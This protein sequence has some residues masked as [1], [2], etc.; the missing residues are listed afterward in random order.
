MSLSGC[1]VRR[2]LV[3]AAALVIV[4][5]VVGVVV[6]RGGT[7][8]ASAA[9]VRAK[10]AEGVHFRQSISGEFSVRTRNPGAPPRGCLHF[11]FPEV[12][13]PSKFVIGPDGSYSSLTLPLDATK[14]HDIAYNARAGTETSFGLFS[15]TFSDK[16]I[17][18]F[19][20]DPASLTYGP[21]AQ[22]GVWV[23]GALADRNPRVKNT[24]LDG[25]SAWS[26]TITFMPGENL[27][28]TYG[29]RV[30]VVVDQA[31]GLVLQ[32]TQ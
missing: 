12:P 8:T 30:D 23:Q 22:L 14:R 18:A 19:N 31:T 11:C 25:R 4:T 26:L 27:Y 6:V 16:Y 32:V 7:D 2:A 17:R 9:E 24:T 1:F 3:A 20:L 15:G 28:T 13:Q 21:E 29:K 5:V 10:L